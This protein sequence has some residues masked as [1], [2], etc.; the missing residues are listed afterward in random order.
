MLL[1][2]GL[3]WFFHLLAV[4]LNEGVLVK[5]T[6]RMF[7]VLLA[8]LSHLLSRVT[9]AVLRLHLLFGSRLLLFLRLVDGVGRPVGDR[10]FGFGAARVLRT[11]GSPAGIFGRLIALHRLYLLLN[12]DSGF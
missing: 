7:H 11:A 6:F 12:G 8:I 5:M 9:V 2:N 3:G 1:L 10:L 4:F